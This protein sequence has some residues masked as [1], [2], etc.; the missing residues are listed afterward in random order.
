MFGS[1]RIS[2]PLV[3]NKIMLWHKRLGHPSFSYLKHLFPEFSKEISSSQFHCDACHLAK[4]HRVSFN[5]RGYSASKAFYLIHSDVWD[6]S[7]IKTL[8]GKKWFMT[9]IDD[10]TRVCWVYLMEKK[11]EVE[12]R[13]QDFQDF[14]NMIKNQFNTTIGILRSDNGTEYFNKYLSTFLVTNGIIH[15]FSC[16]DTPQQ[17]GVAERKNRHLLEVTRAI[18]FSMNVPKYL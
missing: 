8:S 11:S 2:S 13:F 4:D 1:S 10:H 15:Q 7:K 17:N 9:F 6:P 12:Q 18:M 16:R 5:S 14:F 3:S